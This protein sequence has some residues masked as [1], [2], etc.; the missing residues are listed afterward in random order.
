MKTPLAFCF[1][2]NALFFT[3]LCNA[4]NADSVNKVT[5]MADAQYAQHGF[6]YKI[7]L[8]KN[9]RAVWNTP[10]A[11]DKFYFKTITRQ[12]TPVKTGGGLQ[13]VSLLITDNNNTEWSLRSVKKNPT[14][15]ISPF[16]Q[17]TFVRKIV[18]DQI[19]ASFPYGALVVPELADA[20]QIDHATPKLVVIN[21]D[22]LLGKFRD[23]FANRLC[24]LEERNPKGKSISTE[25]LLKLKDSLPGILIDTVTYLKCRLLDMVIGDWDR[26]ADQYRWYLDNPKELKMYKPIPN[27]RDQVFFKSTGVLPG[28]IMKLGFMRYLE[29][30]NYEVKNIKG[31]TQRGAAL[32][33]KILGRMTKTQVEAIT[34][35]VVNNL[36]D[37]VVQHALLHL[38]IEIQNNEFD[39]PGKLISRRNALPALSKK[40]FRKV[41][42]RAN[43]KNIN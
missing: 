39:L 24:F 27:D 23:Q 42:S 5:V 1:L 28:I 17:K 2:M 41:I 3:G 29:G 22:T 19:S 4:Q 26:H 18:Q 36:S 16:W 31:F 12:Y 14:K 9:Y 32:D 10:V 34:N 30:F 25:K 43:R 20:L 7:I 15:W 33:K 11:A 6:L 13:T 21:D 38:P 35:E 8:G 40:Y 37:D